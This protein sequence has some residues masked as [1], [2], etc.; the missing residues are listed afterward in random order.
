MYADRFHKWQDARAVKKAQK[1]LDKRKAQ[2]LRHIVK[3]LP[4][5]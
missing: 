4:R 1:E 2:L 5:A 3:E